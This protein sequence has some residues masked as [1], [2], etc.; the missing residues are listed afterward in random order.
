MKIRRLQVQLSHLGKLGIGL[1]YLRLRYS[2]CAGIVVINLICKYLLI[3][4]N[5]NNS[6]DFIRTHNFPIVCNKSEKSS[7]Y[8]GSSKGK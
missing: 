5:N 4:V 6:K 2:L 3:L 7:A 8:L 1:C